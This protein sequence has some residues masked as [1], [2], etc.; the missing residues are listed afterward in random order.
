MI[1]EYLKQ[2]LVC[3]SGK[4]WCMAAL[5]TADEEK[6]REMPAQWIEDYDTKTLQ[7]ADASLHHRLTVKFFHPGPPGRKELEACA[8]GAPLRECRALASFVCGG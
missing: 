7:G 2:K 5:N 6:G 8:A 1:V 3:W 4:P